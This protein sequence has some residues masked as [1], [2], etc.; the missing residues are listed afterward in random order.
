MKLGAWLVASVLVAGSLGD[1]AAEWKPPANPRAQAILGEARNDAKEKRYEDALAKHIWIFEHS[2][3]R[4]PAMAGV[5][6]SFALSDWLSLGKAYPP[7]MARLREFRD[8]AKQNALAGKET[9]RSFMDLAA[10][11]K[12]LGEQAA[13]AETFKAIDEKS[14]Q[15]AAT[16]YD[17]AQPALVRVKAYTLCEKYLEPEKRFEVMRMSRRGG[18]EAAKNPNL[19]KSLLEFINKK[20]TN[21]VTTLV[22]LLVVNKRGDEAQEVARLARKEW[23]DAAFSKA[24]DEALAGTVPTPWP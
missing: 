2:L 1:A 15:E 3:E 12:T 23:D 20:F 8:G 18:L 22:A 11:D 5:R 9:R 4:E 13:T 16:I 7:A 10:I 6:L 17:L 14:E 21:D 24:I 19:G